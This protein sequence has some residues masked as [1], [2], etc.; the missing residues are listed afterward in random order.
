MAK[1][2]SDADLSSAGDDFHILWTIKKSLELLNFN[3]Q[4]L[5]AITIEGFEKN[6]SK[7]IDPSGEK[8]L[9]IDLTEYFGGSDFESA[10]S[11]T[12]SQLKYST[13]RVGENFTFSKLYE[14]KKSNSYDGS[15][16]HR[17]ATI[18]KTFIDQFGR[19]KI[20]KKIKIKLISNRNIN[21]SH[22][23]QIAQIQ[24]YLV[25]NKRSISFNA[26]L[27]EFPDIS[28]E[29]FSKLKKASGLNLNEFTDFIRL[30]DFE[31]CGTNSR[32]LLKFELINSIASASI[33]SQNQFNSLFQMIWSKMMPEKREERTLTF[34]DVVANFGFSSIENLFPVTQNFE[35]NSNVIH[36]EQLGDIISIIENNTSYFPI[37]IHGGA[38]IGKSTITHQIKDSLPEYSECILFDCYGAGKYQNPE[39]KRHLHRN[40]ILQLA[41]ELAKKIGTEFLLLQNESDDIFLKELIKR[42]RDG[43]DILRNRNPSAFLVFIIDAADNSVTAAKN[44]GEKSFIEDL[45]NIE[46]PNGCHIIVTSRSYRKESLNLPNKYTDVELKPFSFEE[47]TLFTKKVFPRITSQ[48]IAEFHKYSKGIPRVQFYSLNLKIQGISEI[49]NYLKP[50]GKVVGDLILD[51]IEHAISRVGKDKKPLV[52]QFFKLL[53]SLPRP[54]PI[55]YLSE[56]MKVEIDFLKDLSSDIWNGLI[57]EDDL[58][59]FRDEDFE[60]YIGETYRTTLEELQEI[61]KIF[62][63]KSETDEYAATNLGSLLFNA[64]YK[65]EL[66]D[67]VLNRKLLLFPKDPIRNK[68]VYINRAKLALKISHDIQDNLTYFKL[69]FIVAEELKTDKALSNLLITYPDLVSRFGDEV[70][71]SRL[72]LNSDEKP[73]AGAFHLKLAGIY[74]RKSETKE[75]ALKHLKTAGEWLNWRRNKKDEDLNDYPISSLDIAYEVETVLRISGLHK[76]IR[77]INRWKPKEIRLSAGNY[78]VEN[79]ISFSTKENIGEW[80]QHQNFRT[81]VKIFIICKLFQYNHPINFD[82]N[83]IA[84]Y[85]LNILTKKTL[86]FNKRFQQLLV[87]FCGILAHH[88]TNPKIILDILGFIIIKPLEEIPHFFNYSDKDEEIAMD[89]TLAKE[90]LILSLNNS[91]ANIESFFPDKFRNVDKIKDYEKRKSIESDK[92]EFVSF[93]KYAVRIYQLR[94]DLLTERITQSE[95]LSKFETICGNIGNDYELKYQYGYQINDRLTFL[96]GKLAEIALFFKEKAERIDFI[97]K[98]LDNQT[99]KLKLRFEVLSKTILIEDLIKNS[100]KIL[101]E[102]DELIKDSDLSAKEATDNYIK[103]L[104]F[105]SKIDNA[106]S[107]YFFDEAIK[108]TS[109]IDYEAFAQILCIYYLSEIGITKPN[110]QL[111]YQYARFVE[112]CDIK[113]GSYDKKHFPYREGL[114]GLAN[115]DMPSMFATICRWHHRNVVRIGEEIT[116]L[117]KIAVEKGYINHIVAGSMILLKTNYNFKELESL[118]KLLIQ[119]F[120]QTGNS[121]LKSNY[122]DSEYKHLRLNKDKHF[123]RKIYDEIKSGR[124]IDSNIVNEIKNY[125]EFLDTL[126]DKKTKTYTNNGFKK[127]EFAHNIDLNKLDYTLT[128]EIE[129]AIDQIVLNNNETYNHRWTIENFLTDIVNKCSPNEYTLFLSVLVEVDASLIDFHSFE[130]TLKK[131]FTQWDYYPGVKIWK[132]D[133]FNNV[134]STKLQHFDY[135][136]TLNIWSLR[137]FASLFNIDNIQLA[138]ALVGILPQKVDL[139]TDESIY[140]SF[141]LIKSKLNPDENEQLLS[142]VLERWNSKIKPDV[143]DGVWAEDLTA[144][145]TSDVNV[146]NLLRFIL[147]HPDK[148]LRWRAIHSIRRLASLNN[149]EIL[150]VLLDKQNEKDCFPFQ[151]KDYIYYW[152]SAKLYL[153]IAID[154]ISIEN[155][156]ILIPFKDTFYKELICEDL[157]H[158]LIKHYIKKSCLNLYKFDQSIFTDI[159]LQS[160]EGINKSKLG[161]VEEKQYSRQQRRYSIKS[162]QKWKFRFDSIDTLPYWYSRIGDIFNLSEYDVADI[163]DQ[164]ISEKWGFVGKP[165][166]DDYLRSQLYDR[167]WY[168]TRN[169]HGSNPEIEDLSTYFEY[170][171]MYCAANFFLEHEPFLKT[172]YSDYWDSWEGW[173]NSEA[174]AFDNFWLSDIRTAIPL[175]L[176]YWKNNVESFDLLWRDSIPEEYFDENVGFSKENK[177]EFLNVY[178]AIKKYT[179]EN[180]ETITFTSCLVSNRGSEALLRALH[181][182]KDS[183]DYY[184][185][186]EKDSDNDDS[187]ID[188]VDFTFK[189]WLRESRS[190]YDGLD[191]NDSLFSDSSKGYFVFGDIVNSYFNIKYDNTYTKGYFED[192]E[193]SIYEN[194][195]E[196]T[197]DN[198]RKYNTDT[199]TSGCFFKVKSEFILNFLKLEQKSLIIRCIVDRQLEE[200]NYRE[201]NSDNTNQ[202]KLYLIKSDGTVKTLRGR[203]YK[204]G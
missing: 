175:K 135:G 180:Q 203:D 146:A 109:E 53:I 97:I 144:P 30:L 160:I 81:D 62:I 24:D 13:R 124:F 185:P 51:K 123:T 200:R 115:I 74:S 177:N 188:E 50:N 164:F 55:A 65:Q 80:S 18:F 179:G 134:I 158:V 86:K 142:W 94:S 181:T 17:L 183:Y 41:N 27:N 107:Q 1:T 14:G 42:I 121:E 165:N 104:L 118:Y 67:I 162:E 96:S 64:E 87:Q 7:T 39:D 197:D 76:A 8:F 75:I 84:N 59:S 176:D 100:F 126:E 54:V 40:A 79:L 167:D 182:T 110:P 116:S 91:E 122:I 137:E 103:C 161:Y 82:L 95:C 112:Y 202:V 111:A 83:L 66:V 25:N 35:N 6:L 119:K 102:S 90:T 141:E 127:E 2:I 150:K 147:G 10:D 16:I 92:K 189:G 128:K 58:F 88:K 20:I 38:G 46:I 12:I 89:I 78:L 98:S 193:V 201:R 49:I 148:K 159:E 117:I 184:L 132:K 131:A 47:T 101:A 31:D 154:R 163:A 105:S 33:K 32:Q 153:W 138:D 44:N 191:T 170:H 43:V 71:L 169:D 133:N 60:N 199:E 174:N 45:V 5:K 143:A 72:K 21:A 93:Y 186:L 34:I 106:F 145:E 171:A 108:A 178:G 9:G 73:W 168:L 139:L 69:L 194:W 57:L 129:K 120:D 152:M 28:K 29:P 37:C 130:I 52:E 196:I 125:I 15:I 63:T 173:L 166:D 99:D 56:I 187:E 172:D 136:N 3:N 140:S 149:V 26:V 70:S 157:P 113:L 4:S 114:L 85:L 195:N 61:T 36:R 77:A 190:E 48:E 11:I 192:N 22:L 68:E 204:I 19:E 155:P 151:N 156:E 23:K 198:Y